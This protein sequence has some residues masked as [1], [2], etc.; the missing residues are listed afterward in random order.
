MPLNDENIAELKSGWK[1]GFGDD[2]N[3]I[4][5]FFAVYD[6][7]NTRIVRRNSYGNIVAQMHY[8]TFADTKCGE[9]GCYI[10]GVTTLPD[11][12]GE[13]LAA[14]MIR[15]CLD[16][17]REQGVGYAVLIT[18]RADLRK[19]YENLG[20]V[21]RPVTINVCGAQ[22]SMN[23]AMEDTSLNT[24]MYYA[25]KSELSDFTSEIKI[26]APGK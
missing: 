12:R 20:F 26:N 11:Y 1:L 23:F 8:F 25:I 3:F 6:S 18:E 10:Y 4:D 9:A 2:D 14:S 16:I 5:Y 13:G 17:L 19:W 24:G 7:D 21:L 15:E 22:D